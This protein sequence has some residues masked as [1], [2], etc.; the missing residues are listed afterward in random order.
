MAHS[1]SPLFDEPH[2][3]RLGP[4]GHA[5]P[6]VNWFLTST[7]PEASRSRANVNRWY[8]ALPDQDGAF[9]SRLRSGR[10][11]D[12]LQAIDELYVHHL[13]AS[14]LRMIAYEEDGAGPDFRVYESGAL[15]ASVEVASLFEKAEWAAEDLRH[16]R[17][18]DELNKRLDLSCGF[19]IGFE[20][21]ND[22][23]TGDPAP[24]KLAD[25]IRRQ[26][27]E[28]PDP[29]RSNLRLASGAA[30]GFKRVYAA[31]PVQVGVTFWPLE[32]HNIPGAGSQDRV[33]SIG[34]MSGGWVTDDDRVRAKITE[35]AG[36][37]YDLRCRPYLIV[38]GVHAAFCDDG[39]FLNAL[40]G[41]NV[42][43]FRIGQPGSE[44]A[45]RLGDG[46]FG[47]GP[48]GWKNRRLSAV[49]R[50]AAPNTWS[51]ER[52]STVLFENPNPTH[53]IP[54]LFIPTRVFGIVRADD[55]VRHLDWLDGQGIDA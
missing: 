37:K 35:K 50:L 6:R 22:A 54:D 29:R 20:I 26:F 11:V 48:G 13:L 36:G 12:H 17:V 41:S 33:V 44:R 40:Y 28:L 47:I 46:V 2:V 5:E 43:Q 1:S 24:A 27:E 32:P 19:F 25:W 49:C 16:N 18:A 55:Q 51:P 3:E 15:V 8:R 23:G 52:T 39:D 38:V 30:E 53:S 34:R 14:P 7:R 21:E 31:G 4:M 9:A 45:D 10:D 42:V